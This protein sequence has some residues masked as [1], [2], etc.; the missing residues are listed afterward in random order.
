MSRFTDLHSFLLLTL[1]K[2]IHQIWNMVHKKLRRNTAARNTLQ[3]MALLV[4]PHAQCVITC[5]GDK[6]LSCI[7]CPFRIK[8]GSSL[9]QYLIKQ[10]SDKAGC[11]ITIRGRSKFSLV[12]WHDVLTVCLQGCFLIP[13]LWHSSSELM[14]AGYF[15]ECCSGCSFASHKHCSNSTS[16]CSRYIPCAVIKEEDVCR[17]QPRQ[18]ESCLR[19]SQVKGLQAEHGIACGSYRYQIQVSAQNSKL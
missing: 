15:F 2:G 16:S 13:Q 17:P 10:P 19:Q 11:Q 1:K 7:Y 14:Q 5:T 6:L 3:L 18:G 12:D 8:A 9:S 4:A